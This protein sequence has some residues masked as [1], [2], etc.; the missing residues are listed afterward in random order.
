M[1]FAL[2]AVLLCL[3]TS[4]HAKPDPPGTIKADWLG[5]MAA[6]CDL[7]AHR[8]R[9]PIE[10][11]VL[12]NT[13]Y[14]LQGYSFKTRELGMLFASD[15]AWY[16]PKPKVTSKFSPA[17]SACIKTLKAF[18]AK[19]QGGQAM[20]PLKM[21]LFSDRD[22]YLEARG[23]SQMMA[24][25]AEATLTMGFGFSLEV[26]CAQ[27][28]ALQIYTIMCNADGTGCGVLVPGMGMLPTE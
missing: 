27:C 13:A 10:A 19:H 3:A 23:H 14:A 9:T 5:L 15:G 4:A 25:K 7:V 12:R 6:K 17:E 8:V 21:A 28:T 2:P 20:K 24:G 1:R 26:Q 22:A 11:S 18:E 16:V